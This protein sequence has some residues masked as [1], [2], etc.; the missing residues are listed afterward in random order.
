MQI[1][2]ASPKFVRKEDVSPDV[3][4]QES[5]IA[6]EQARRENKPEKIWD[7]IVNGKVQQYYGQ[8]CLMEQP[9]IKP[10]DG[11]QNGLTVAQVVES[12][13][14]KVGATLIPRRFIRLKV[15]KRNKSM[16]RTPRVRRVVLKLSGEALLGRGQGGIDVDACSRS[17]GN[18]V[19][20]GKPASNR[21]RGGRGQHLARGSRSGKRV[22]PGDLGPD[23]DVGHL[24]NALA[25]QDA[26]EKTGAPTRV[27]SAMEV[28]KVAEPYI[29]RRAIRHLEKGRIVVFAAG[30]GNPFFSTDTAAALRASEIEASAVLK[31]TQVD[32][33]YNAD[34]HRDPSAK[35]YASLT[36][37]QALRDQLGVMDATALSLC[38]EN[39]I[40]VRVFSLK[41][42][43]NIRRAIAG[44]NVGT[45]TPGHSSVKDTIYVKHSSPAPTGL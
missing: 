37:L 38:L 23:G 35:K 34:P 39:K 19:R 9:F 10:V 8:F 25:L 5:N 2:A 20:R 4:E 32:G 36:L 7:K 33:V 15:G 1:A 27:M 16:P 22:G 18:S 6:R 13:S 24:V 21:R 29:R 11:E 43:G 30:T 41:E 17:R 31:A 26:L 12:V 45:V 14:K 42:P 28:A 40:P 3:I 44:E